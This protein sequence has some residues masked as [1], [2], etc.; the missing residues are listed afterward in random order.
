MKYLVIVRHTMDDIPIHLC[1][2][3]EEALVRAG[4]IDPDNPE[5][6]TTPEYWGTDASTPMFVGIVTF[7]DTGKAIEVENVLDLEDC[8]HG[9]STSSE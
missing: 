4:A 9:R 3:K 2:T 6:P 8:Q 1:D 5:H 7:D